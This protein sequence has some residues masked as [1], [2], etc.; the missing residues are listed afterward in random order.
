MKRSLS[1]II[2]SVSA[3][4]A[5]SGCVMLAGESAQVTNTCSSDDDCEGGVCV[6]VFGAPACVA[7]RAD[8]PGLILEVQPSAESSYGAGTSFLV[9][10][11]G[12]GLAAQ[13][14][15]GI[16]LEQDLVLPRSQVSPIEL[17][18]DYDYKD[19]P[20]AASRVLAADFV[21]YRNS[22][23]AGLPDHE[24][25]A[26]A[27]DGSIDA[28]IVDLPRGIYDMHVI[29]HA[30]ADCAGLPPP[31]TFLS[32]LDISQGGKLDL[33]LTAPP[34]FIGGTIGFPKG[35]DLTGWSI[36]VV[37]PKRGKP[38]SHTQALEVEPLNLYASYNLEYFWSYSVDSS[39]VL[40]LTPP[41]GV[42]APRLFWEIAALSPLDPNDTNIAAN[43]V[44][45]DLDAVGR[46]VD[47]FVVDTHGNAVVSTIT[48]RSLE[49]SGN[50]SNNANFSIVVDTGSDGRFAT[51][52]PPGRYKVTAHPT[53]DTSKAVT[54]E[55]WEIVGDACV[56]GKGL[57]IRDK[58]TI[59]GEVVLPNGFPLNS[60]T[61]TVYPSR[62]PAR[63]YLSS[64]LVADAPTS[65]ISSASLGPTGSFA[66]LADPGLVD[67]L[68]VPPPGSLFPW[69][70]RSQLD[71]KPND[72]GVEVFNLPSLGLSHPAIIGG[73]VRGPDNAIVAKGTVR[74]WMPVTAAGSSNTVVIQIGETTTEADGRFTLPLAPSISK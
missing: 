72:N 40:R 43:L 12:G 21:F 33:H 38:I 26:I 68:V 17:Y 39:P 49:L 65:Q 41:P 34:R 63:P 20:L 55:E 42:K 16:V 6:D 60:G 61:A 54:T 18:I 31:P 32:G 22:I 30:P 4:F 11:A 8:L 2:L 7:T 50:A 44:L 46:D 3:L 51:K 58:S 52:L 1:S 23:H 62:S 9:P 35:Q 5:L 37:E 47:A 57:V 53:F 71:V 14:D 19:C 28:Y 29:P 13:S 10:F 73:V 69:L 48:F 59:S 64:H 66:L 36:Q 15:T 74:A 70:V 67:L 56:C 24:A 25:T 45:V 27:L